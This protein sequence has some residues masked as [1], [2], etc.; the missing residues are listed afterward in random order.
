[1][2]L[3]L[4]HAIETHELVLDTWMRLNFQDNRGAGHVLTARKETIFAE[5]VQAID[6]SQNASI[7]LQYLNFD[8]DLRIDNQP[9]A[10]PFI[11]HLRQNAA[12][13]A[14]N[15]SVDKHG[16]MID[17]QLDLA[18]VP[19]EA[20][21]SLGVLVEP[22]ELLKCIAVRVPEK[23]MA[24]GESWESERSVKLNLEDGRATLGA[25]R[26][27]QTYLGT[28]RTGA[29]EEAVIA[30]AGKIH[31]RDQGRLNGVVKGSAVIEVATG[32]ILS[33]DARFIV[34]ATLKGLGSETKASGT[35]TI[36]CRRGA[37]G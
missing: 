31:A 29:R 25:M 2:K 23:E 17:C 20:R 18:Q 10:L 30:L 15:V 3:K 11:D 13:L 8:A 9:Q 21:E 36:R 22:L 12:A 7:R 24:P 35:L 16:E 4:A 33:A 27:S 5:T 28:R 37:K 32:K 19:K 34:N 26:L 1:V 14:A 6:E